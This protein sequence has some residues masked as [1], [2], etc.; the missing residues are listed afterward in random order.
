M[1]LIADS[2]SSK[3]DWRV[4]ADNGTI[5]QHR[6]I[7]FNPTYQSREEMISLLRDEFLLEISNEVNQI[8][9]YGAGCS[10]ESGRGQVNSALS[11]IFP[12]A[13]IVIEHDMLAAAKAT[14]GHDAG[15]ACILGTG[16][17]SCD[18]DGK[19]IMESMPAPGYILGDFGGGSSIGKKFLQDFIYQEMPEA[20]YQKAVDQLGLSYDMIIHEV[21]KNP[22]PGRY[23]ASFCKFLTENKADPYCYLL[24]WNAFQDFLKR[25]VMKYEG[26]QGKPVNF[27]GSIAFH[28]SDIL[29][30]A[31]F[32]LGI[33]VNL[34]LES[35]IAGLTLYHQ[36]P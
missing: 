11:I 13:E 32:D 2:G 12:K 33:H 22:F 20:I 34:I 17:N 35:P 30:N 8:F 10:S 21:Y 26:F 27:V 7:G 28:N 23:M 9:Y 29:R 36:K 5:K 3:T 18:Y 24:F 31:A 25:Y 19:N 1:I 16:S 4:I 14:C 15:I 6:G